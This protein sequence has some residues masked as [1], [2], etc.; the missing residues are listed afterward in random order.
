MN[1]RAAQPLTTVFRRLFDLRFPIERVQPIEY[2]AEAVFR[3]ASGDPKTMTGR[4]EYAAPF[5][6]ELAIEPAELV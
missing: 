5:L 6:K 2:I 3:L 1:S 4:I